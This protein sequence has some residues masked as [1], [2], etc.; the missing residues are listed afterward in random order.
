MANNINTTR[1][2]LWLAC[3]IFVFI[4]AGVV[5][6]AHANGLAELDYGQI[7]SGTLLVKGSDGANASFA[8]LLNTDVDL[9][10]SGIIVRA[11]VTQHFLNP[12]DDWVEGIYLFPLPDDAAVDHLRLKVGGRIIEGVIQEK[13]EAKRNYEKAKGNGQRATLFTQERPNLFTIAVANIGPQEEVQVEI[14]YQQS[15]PLSQGEFSLRFPLT[16]TPRYIPG[17]ALINTVG[18]AQFT[19]TGSQPNTDVVPDA[20]HI[21]PQLSRYGENSN[22]INIRVDLAPGFDIVDLQSRYHRVEQKSVDAQH[23]RL[24]LNSTTHDSNS[25]FVLNWRAAA[26]EQ[27]Y[28]G[29]YT[30]QWQG[31]YYSMLMLTPPMQTQDSANLPRDLVFVIDTSGSMGGEPIRQA[32]Q[33]LIMAIER[34]QAQ[35]RFNLIEFN[36]HT[37]SL[38]NNVQPAS[39]AMRARAISFVRALGASGGTEMYPA[40]DAALTQQTAEDRSGRIRQVVFLTDGAVGN[41]DQLFELIERKLDNSRLFTIGIGSAPNS[42]FMR[43]AAEFG[44]GSF[45]HIGSMEIV[46]EQMTEL[47]RKLE[48]PVLTNLN[49]S[50]PSEFEAEFYPQRIP[51]LYQGEPIALVFKTK[52]LPAQLQLSGAADSETFA[53][54]LSFETAQTRAGMNVFWARRKMEVLMDKYL[55]SYEPEQKATLKQSVIELSLGHHLVSRFTS[56]IA[57]DKTPVRRPS[58]SLSSHALKSNPPKGTQFGLPQTATDAELRILKGFGIWL[59]ALMLYLYSRVRRIAWLRYAF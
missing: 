25:D 18:Q 59:L 50:I 42:Y 41:E 49:I 45:T 33:A 22:P 9:Q 10:V 38:F 20:S 26:S 24:T 1:S 43:K 36:S 39:Q 53:K 27:S 55:L 30:Q 51:D 35:D 34:L 17:A 40:L 15:V 48:S 16:V 13:Q 54:T 19:G 3:A 29:L 32:R 12:G 14:E 7:K 46:A 44:R 37:R 8:P 2:P 21:T 6:P 23:Y 11:K 31:S 56:L 58:E 28:V 52:G 4:C 57:V 47:F 5:I